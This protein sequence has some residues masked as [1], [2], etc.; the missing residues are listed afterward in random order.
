[1]VTLTVMLEG[2]FDMPEHRLVPGGVGAHLLQKARAL[3]T[4]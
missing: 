2:I 1:L 4:P 3:P